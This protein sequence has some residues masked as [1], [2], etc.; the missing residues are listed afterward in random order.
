[1]MMKRLMERHDEM[2]Y[3]LDQKDMYILQLPCSLPDEV[4]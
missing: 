4:V 1:M 3:V 2:R